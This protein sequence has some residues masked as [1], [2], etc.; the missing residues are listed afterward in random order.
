MTTTELTVKG[1]PAPQGS[2]DFFGKGRFKEASPYLEAWRNA[3]ITQAMLDRKHLLKLSGPLE[4]L[5]VFWFERPAEHYTSKGV[6]KDSAPDMVIVTPDIDKLLRST[7][8]G[9]TQAGVIED[10]RFI[11]SQASQERYSNNGFQGAVI[12]IRRFER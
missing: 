10:D 9:L 1:R 3:I 12:R 5:C 11:V 7:Y 6:L 8:D 2:K 4:V